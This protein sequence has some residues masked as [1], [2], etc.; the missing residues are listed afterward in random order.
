MNCLWDCTNALTPDFVGLEVGT[1][2]SGGEIVA[3]LAPDARVVK[4]IP[5]AAQLLMSEVP[6]VEGRPVL[7]LLCSDDAAQITGANIPIDG[8]WTA[9]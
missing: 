6:T 9:E 7:C 3:R 8:G 4:A 1:T 2:N 5:P